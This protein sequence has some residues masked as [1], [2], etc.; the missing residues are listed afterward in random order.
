[1]NSGDRGQGPDSINFMQCGHPFNRVGKIGCQFQASKKR[2]SIPSK[3]S[4]NGFL[5][6]LLINDW[7]GIVPCYDLAFML[8][9]DTSKVFLLIYF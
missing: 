2:I 7:I 1:M 8:L 3:T 4:K 9:Q 5:L 6:E